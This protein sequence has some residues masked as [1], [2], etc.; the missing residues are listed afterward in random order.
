MLDGLELWSLIG[1]NL[2]TMG[3]LVIEYLRHRKESS[4]YKEEIEDHKNELENQKKQLENQA[5]QLG[6][7]NEQLDV[8]RKKL[9][10][11][12]YDKCRQ[13]HFELLKIVLNK[14]FLNQIYDDVPKVDKEWEDFTDDEKTIC[15]CYAL[16][17]ALFERLF[18]L[19]DKEMIDDKE[20]G[21][22]VKWLE[23][24][25]KNWLFEY[26][27]VDASQSY[28]QKFTQ[29]ISDKFHMQISPKQ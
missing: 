8:M 29:W 14:P 27:F 24:M 3:Y 11:D 4:L 7:Q 2:A 26:N 19:R 23:S 12:T 17:F 15:H 9:Y 25:S 6:T 28:D 13:D 22:W 1:A 20:W 18:L 10:Q 16:H 21:E 5:A